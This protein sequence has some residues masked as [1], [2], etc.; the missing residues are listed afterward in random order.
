MFQCYAESAA[1]AA[2]AAVR[3][4]VLPPADGEPRRQLYHTLTPRHLH[5]TT[6]PHQGHQFNTFPHPKPPPSH[7]KTPAPSPSHHKEPPFPSP[8]HPK[9]PYSATIRSLYGPLEHTLNITCCRS[10]QRLWCPDD[11]TQLTRICQTLTYLLIVIYVLVYP[12]CFRSIQ[13]TFLPIYF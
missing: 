12:C 1:G 8:S 3:L 9:A 13:P 2:A 11:E 6:F 7:L 10:R 4:L 5:S